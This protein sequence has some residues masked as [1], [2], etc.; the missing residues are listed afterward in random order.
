[1]SAASDHVDR[2]V[3]AYVHDLLSADEAGRVEAH[4]HACPACGRA[5]DLARRRLA[6]L[7]AVP[8]VEPSAALVPATLEHIHDY[9]YRRTQRRNRIAWGLLGSLAA[10]TLVLIGLQM[11]YALLRPGTIDLLVLGQNQLLAATR[12]SLRVRVVDRNGG[13][14]MTG[15]PV[16]VALLAGDGRSEELARFTTD[17]QGAGSPP[18]Q[19]PDWAD[20]RYELVVSALTPGGTQTLR[21]PVQLRR[22]WQLMLSTDKPLYQ[23][24]Q[25]IR[26]RALALRRPD[27][28]PVAGQEAVFTLADPR[29][30]VLFKHR[31][32][33]SQYGITASDC[34]LAAEIAEGAYTLACKVG[35]TESKQTVEIKRYTL[36]KFLVDV[37]PDRSYYAPG[38]LARVRVQA[39]YFFGKPVA[40]AAVAVGVWVKDAGEREHATVTAVTDDRGAAE[41]TFMT[42]AA[43]VGQP[44]DG[45]DA[46]VRL[47]ATVTDPADQKETRAVERIVTPR[48]VRLDVL[49]EAGTLVQGVA[50]TVF[51]L[52][53]RPDG[54]PV[55][56]ARV[57]TTGA[58][59]TEVVTDDR[60]AGSFQLMAAAGAADLNLVVVAPGGEVLERTSRRLEVRGDA[61][62]FL[63]RTD[64]AVYRGGETMTVTALGNGV[65]PVFLDLIRDGQTL[66]SQTIELSGGRGEQ[67]VDLPADLFG[68]LQLV[69]YRFVGPE[70]LPFRKTRV[71][72]VTPPDG[73][74]VHATLD[75]P[76]Y[77]PG[78]QATLNLRLTD[79]KGRPTPGAISLAGVDERVF[80][81]LAQR[82]G[83]EATFYTLEKELLKPVYAIYPWS[84]DD[85]PNATRRD[86]ALFA[87]TAGVT[88]PPPT[89]PEAQATQLNASGVHTLAMRSLPEVQQAVSKLRER[90]LDQVR[91]GWAVLA[92]MAVLSGYG[93]L[94]LFLSVR[95]VLIVHGIAGLGLLCMVGGMVFLMLMM[96]GRAGSKFSGVA[97]DGRFFAA[98]KSAAP[99][100]GPPRMA[101]EMSGMRVGSGAT[102]PRVRQHFP[103]TLVWK[104][105]L[106]T[107]DAGRLPPL[108]IPLADSI[109]TWRLAASAVSAD[110]R[111]GAAQLP[112]KVFQPFFVELNLP[113]TFTRGDE[114]GVP[115]VVYN[116]LDRPQTVA[117]T[118]AAAPWYSLTGPAEQKLELAAGEVRST[119]Y[120]LKIDKVGTH[121]L[122]VTALAGG[123][124]DAVEREIDVV[125]DGRRV[126]TAHSG[127][128]AR[129][130]EVTL[131]VPANAVDGSVKAFVKFYPSGFS[132]L[133]EGLDSIFQMPYGCFEQTSST[134]Y[135]NVLA[136]DYLRQNRLSVPAV[137]AKAR[138]YI[139]LGYQRL[140]GFEVAGGGFDWYGRPPA[141]V[142]LT[143]YGLMEF[144]D[145]AR[146]H[147]V[148]A[149]LLQR[150]R[151]WLL[152]QR[153]PDGSWEAMR[154][155]HFAGGGADADTA[156]LAL[157]AYVTWAV[158]ADGQ[159]AND[160]SLT[161]NWLLTHRPET[162]ADPHAL[163]LLC[164][165]LLAMDPQGTDAAPYLARLAELR[166][167]T[168]D[169][170]QAFWARPAGARTLFYAGGVS[171]QVETTALAAGAAARQGPSAGERP[172]R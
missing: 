122:K 158:F 124:G 51:V 89:A 98:E 20:G 132:Q 41:V 96:G 113:T 82:P 157:T 62:D 64:R 102:P 7:Q 32:P 114:V 22:S 86:Q 12:T 43:L 83:M 141:D 24:G 74:Q 120:T 73:L 169:G 11:Y 95:T 34:P 25:T 100:S 129:P 105:E 8:A 168:D 155:A 104:P 13:A 110:G 49:P 108:A 133:V 115:V 15:V 137:E 116:Y 81:V 10:C 42:P 167:T 76:E 35:D 85:E 131:D 161:R 55:K 103:E 1:M 9:Q 58:V 30:T 109:T 106:I 165:A 88:P 18:L 36:P 139:L 123:V 150:T 112:M 101:P 54:T 142:G 17:A 160:T 60:G 125:P 159:M 50:N 147:D 163:A 61:D 47:V 79:G 172:P 31:A 84:P 38:Q 68:T 28:R 127:G 99:A 65:E 48:L 16:V 78:K 118:L 121:R 71:L 80:H 166:Q 14:A 171:G 2:L 134:T 70:G 23:P 119:R 93:L 130:A 149:Q 77:Q 5:L 153:K 156:R 19:V 154:G 6:L 107:D 3:D 46:R 52:V 56:G 146:V 37:K 87:A 29:G 143:A 66:L 75:Q 138:Q 117:L 162:V 152:G 90:R 145:M 59:T 94:W 111:L 92:A 97:A 148:D 26:M 144:Q 72:Y 53:S 40:Q 57:Q 170:R 128:L 33:T 21:R 91:L 151:R 164:N 63:V 140:V 44:G 4:C 67:V 69:A 27:L 136:L 126:E 135:P 39:D 45:G